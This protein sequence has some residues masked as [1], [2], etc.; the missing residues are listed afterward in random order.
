[1]IKSDLV[2]RVLRV[3]RLRAVFGGD[4]GGVRVLISGKIWSG[5]IT[6]HLQVVLLKN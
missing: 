5:F 6:V 3:R 1:M 4:L 2:R